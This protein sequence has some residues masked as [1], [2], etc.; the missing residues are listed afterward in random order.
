MMLLALMDPQGTS[1][2]KKHIDLKGE[3]TSI[4]Y[5]TERCYTEWQFTFSVLKGTKLDVAPRWVR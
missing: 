3:I 5:N 1:D 4:R 2:R